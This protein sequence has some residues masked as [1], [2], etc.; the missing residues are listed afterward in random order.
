MEQ[1]EQTP[2][3]SCSQPQPSNKDGFYILI[4]VKNHDKDSIVFKIKMQ[5]KMKHLMTAYCERKGL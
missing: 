5:T 2:E 3:E 1:S 4:S